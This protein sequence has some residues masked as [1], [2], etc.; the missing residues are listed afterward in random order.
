[1]RHSELNAVRIA[2][3]PMIVKPP[4]DHVML[5]DEGFFFSEYGVMTLF[6][7]G[8]LIHVA[9]EGRLMRDDQVFARRGGA[10]N[11]VERGHHGDGYSVYGRVRVSGFECVDGRGGPG[12]GDVFLNAVDDRL[13]RQEGFLRG[14][15][16]G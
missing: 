9:V 6:E 1:M 3:V 7:L 16:Q 13:G 15:R 2:P 5:A 12:H 11:Y 14:E 8:G 4:D 10:L